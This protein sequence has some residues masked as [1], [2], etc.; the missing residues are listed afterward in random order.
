MS[1]R[2]LLLFAESVK[3]IYLTKTSQLSIS[4]ATAYT[5]LKDVLIDDSL[6]LPAK[7]PSKTKHSYRWS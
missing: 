5:Y 3:L 2:S 7:L 6:N 4:T 1:G